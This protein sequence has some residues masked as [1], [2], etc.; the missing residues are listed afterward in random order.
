MTFV[1]R[2][3][4][5]HSRSEEHT[6]VRQ[7]ISQLAADRGPRSLNA[8]VTCGTSSAVS[9]IISKAIEAF[10]VTRWD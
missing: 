6:G 5:W 1:A 7:P 3:P 8:S 4:N 9:A 10:A 2:S